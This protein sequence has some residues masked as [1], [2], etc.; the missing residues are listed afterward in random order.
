MVHRREFWQ[1]VVEEV[2]AGRGTHR[3]IAKRHGVSVSAL[4]HWLYRLRRERR[5]GDGVRGKVEV[6]P[7][8]VVEALPARGWL[9]ELEVGELKLRF[10]ESA[11]PSYVADVLRSLAC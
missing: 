1:R 5:S 4:Q 2:E 7:V 3:E 8:R 10:G 11:S 9:A 6:L